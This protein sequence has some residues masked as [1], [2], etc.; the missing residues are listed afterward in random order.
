MKTTQTSQYNEGLGPKKTVFVMVT[1]VGCI[2]ILWPKVFYPMMFGSSPPQQPYKDYRPGGAS[3]LNLEKKSILLSSNKFDVL[4]GYFPQSVKCCEVIL[5]EEEF[6]NASAVEI[7]PQLF[8]KNYNFFPEETYLR[9]ERPPHLRPEGIHP[10]MRE[11]GRAIPNTQTVPIIDR[12]R[13]SRDA[14]PRIVEG[15]P[16]PIPG[17]RP[18]MGAGSVHQAQP[19]GNSMGIIMPLYTIAIIAFFCYTIVKLA[20]KKPIQNEPYGTSSSQSNSSFRKD[21]YSENSGKYKLEGPKIGCYHHQL[22]DNDIYGRKHEDNNCIN[23]HN[24]NN[25]ANLCSTNKNGNITTTKFTKSNT[26][27][28]A[29]NI[30]ATINNTTNDITSNITTTTNANNIIV[31]ASNKTSNG[32][33]NNYNNINNNSNSNGHIK[34][35]ERKIPHT[36]DRE[37]LME[38]EWLRKKLEET[39]KAMA[40]LIAEMNNTQIQRKDINNEVSNQNGNISNGHA[41]KQKDHDENEYNGS[42]VENLSKKHDDSSQKLIDNEKESNINDNK[43]ASDRKKRE[44]SV[45]KAVTVMGME[46]TASFEGGQK[47]HRPVTPEFPHH[48]HSGASSPTFNGQEEPKSIYLEGALPHESQILVTDAEIK[49]ERASDLDWDEDD[50]EP[51]VVLSSKISLSLI[52]VSSGEEGADDDDEEKNIELDDVP[53]DSQNKEES[54]SVE[55][56]EEKHHENEADNDKEI[57]D[58]N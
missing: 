57:S 50:N 41:T 16:G 7:G 8:R 46:L 26:T 2:A 24:S 37:Q 40:K 48:E 18:P 19:K 27:T 21:V 12:A 38:I 52:N 36:K 15:R 58:E 23:N 13:S 42:K 43:I 28:S 54:D 20:F 45:D 3:I 10:A 29:T 30:M 35:I 39:E 9:Q 6:V 55:N 11:R 51:A 25:C 5:D 34:S 47:W 32:I 17:M 1:V 22:S 49:T 14:P 31:N 33:S 44:G 4:I 53:E 56:Q